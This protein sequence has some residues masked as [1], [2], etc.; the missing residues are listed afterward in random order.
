M[1]ED[2]TA[3][4]DRMDRTFY[5]RMTMIGNSPV[6]E[7][8]HQYVFLPD[9]KHVNAFILIY[10][11][12]AFSNDKKMDSYTWLC[13]LWEMIQAWCVKRVLYGI[14]CAAV[15]LN[16]VLNWMCCMCYTTADV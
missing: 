7:V 5:H 1:Q 9:S 16:I 12:Y 15:T 8:L 3:V 2:D 13:V 6:S 10:P 14:I 4:N 11:H